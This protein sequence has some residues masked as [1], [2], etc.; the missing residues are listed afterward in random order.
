MSEIK[1]SFF[2]NSCVAL[3]SYLLN[4]PYKTLGFTRV[5]TIAIILLKVQKVNFPI[6]G[7]LRSLANTIL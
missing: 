5:L 1:Q 6:K 4:M 2:R 3:I 7:K